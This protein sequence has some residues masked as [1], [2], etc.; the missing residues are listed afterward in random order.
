MDKLEI[1]SKIKV[2][3][4]SA[5]G[6]LPEMILKIILPPKSILDSVGFFEEL[7]CSPENLK[8]TTATGLTVLLEKPA[9]RKESEPAIFNQVGLYLTPPHGRL[10]WDGKKTAIIKSIKLKSH[11]DTP[12]YLLS[13][14]L[15]YGIIKLGEPKEINLE[16][17]KSL[18][19]KHR[20]GEEERLKWW[21][22]AK[23]LYYYPVSFIRRWDH[24]K[25]WKKQQGAQMFVKNVQFLEEQL[26]GPSLL[27]FA[28]EKENKEYKE[29]ET[30]EESIETEQSKYGD[31]YKV[32]ADP[33]K[34]Y[35]YVAQYHVRGNSVHTDLRMEVNDHLVG[36]TLNTPGVPED[37]AKPQ[38]EYKHTKEDKFQNPRDPS[39][40]KDYQ[41][42]VERK[43][44]QP[45]VWLTVKGKIEAGG[46]G[47]TRFKPAEFEIISTGRVRF[48]AQK[49]DFH[50]Y[51]LDP[52]D[53]WSQEK[54]IKGRWIISLIPRP[55]HYQRAGEG[56]TMWA[57]WKPKDQ[58]PYVEYQKLDESIKKAQ[59]EKGYVLWQ[60]PYK[61]LEKEEDFREGKKK[62]WIY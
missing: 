26:M 40:Q 60:H 19:S 47:A 21:K 31:W 50:E 54:S 9:P 39:S 13:G 42:L 30:R 32:K 22:D 7:R 15:A 37:N 6:Q 10:I 16:Q 41:I 3:L 55:Q 62:T 29:D 58:R 4:E 44:I 46:I 36:W 53:K 2:G 12:I 11:L 43:L 33:K 35:R 27:I 52:D 56:K 34:T 28:K 20:I 48:G 8:L 49:H 5:L 38:V 1:V 17:F 59:D 24:P 57:A 61:G 51:F 23:T 18:E 25:R 14:D 45:K